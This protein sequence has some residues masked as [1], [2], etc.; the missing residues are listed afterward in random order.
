[1]ARFT[2]VLPPSETLPPPVSPVPAVTVSE[3]FVREEFG[4]AASASVP[5][6]RLMPVPPVIVTA[7]S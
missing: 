4:I 2:V 3:E 6:L 5:L 7:E 1:M